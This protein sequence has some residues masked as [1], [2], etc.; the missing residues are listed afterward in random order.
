M[1]LCNDQNTFLYA[2]EYLHICTHTSVI[3]MSTFSYTMPSFS[4]FNLV[5][6]L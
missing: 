4:E 1:R 2:N 6:N 5:S 3:S